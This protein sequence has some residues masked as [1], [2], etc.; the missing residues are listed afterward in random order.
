MLK[1]NNYSESRI[2]FSLVPSLLHLSLSIPLLQ[3]QL[4]LWFE[5]GGVT[6]VSEVRSIAGI[7]RS[8]TVKSRFW[9]V[10]SACSIS[11]ILAEIP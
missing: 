6:V 9:S 11:I 1:L 2:P 10:N 8:A 5:L 4:Y 7:R 3:F